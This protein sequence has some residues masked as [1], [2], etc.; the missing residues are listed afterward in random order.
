[1]DGTAWGD[2]LNSKHWWRKAEVQ[3]L[4]DLSDRSRTG[5]AWS[6]AGRAWQKW[7]SNA[8]RGVPETGKAGSTACLSSTG[9]NCL[10]TEYSLRYGRTGAKLAFLLPERHRGLSAQP[11]S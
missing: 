10:G 7:H 1:M 2:R 5:M 8:L 9:G 4:A 6:N 3:G 11:K